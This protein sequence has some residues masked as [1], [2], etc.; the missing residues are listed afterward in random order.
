MASLK[1]NVA[2]QNFSL[3]LSQTYR[4]LFEDKKFSD[5]TL[6]SD[7]QT[8]FQSHRFILSASSKVF[9][10][11]LENI[12]QSNPVVFL[13]G[14]SSEDLESLL[15]YLYYGEVNIPYNSVQ[16][17]LNTLDSFDIVQNVQNDLGWKG[18]KILKFADEPD[19]DLK[20]EELKESKK[21]KF[22]GEE[23]FDFDIKSEVITSKKQVSEGT[24]HYKD[25][26]EKD[27]KKS[28]KKHALNLKC[29][30]C[31]YVASRNTSLKNHINVI[32]L[33]IRN[34]LPCEVCGNVFSG[35]A[36]LKVHKDSVHEG[37][38]FK[39]DYEGCEFT[40][41]YKSWLKNHIETH[42]N[43]FHMCDQCEY[44]SV[45]YLRLKHHIKLHHSNFIRQCNQCDYKC[46][47]SDSLK[48]H[49]RVKH[50]GKRIACDQCDFK[51]TRSD[52][53]KSHIQS[54]HTKKEFSCDECN[55]GT[56]VEREFRSHKNKAH[57][58]ITE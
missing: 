3:H 52:N 45:H 22:P 56:I 18:R 12:P 28:V 17:F 1:H 19:D 34:L 42:Q 29:S 53:L 8:Q 35:K 49:I 40:S 23:E 39:C 57:L 20:S 24:K 16:Q 31:G 9:A 5:V 55:Y 33:N 43:V 58:P 15:K 36:A 30:F 25:K 11:I 48:I 44:K 14:V 6:I 46:K 10:N 4:C 37:R 50:E 32:H 41:K 51:A 38:E 47:K 26:K 2:L 21:F 7:D 54:K 13:K 27:I